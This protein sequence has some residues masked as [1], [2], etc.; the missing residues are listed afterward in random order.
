MDI[1][2]IEYVI[3]GKNTS[4]VK[5]PMQRKRGWEKIKKFAE[6]TGISDIQCLLKAAAMFVDDVI[7]LTEDFDSLEEI[8]EKISLILKAARMRLSPEKCTFFGINEA[9]REKLKR[10][11]EQGLAAAEETIAIKIWNGDIKE[12]KDQIFEYLGVWISITKGQISWNRQLE[13]LMNKGRAAVSFYR[14]MGFGRYPKGILSRLVIMEKMIQPKIVWGLIVAH[15]NGTQLNNLESVSTNLLTMLTGLP[16]N[17]TRCG[18]RILLGFPSMRYNL[19]QIRCVWHWIFMHPV[20]SEDN[21]IWYLSLD[22]MITEKHTEWAI[23]FTPN[24]N[25][26]RMGIRRENIKSL[27]QFISILKDMRYKGCLEEKYFRI[28]TWRGMMI[29][30]MIFA[31]MDEF[32]DQ[33]KIFAMKQSQWKNTT[34]KRLL[35]VLFERDIK[36]LKEGKSLIL[37]LDIAANMKGY[38]RSIAQYLEEKVTFNWETA[39]FTRNIFAVLTGSICA[40]WKSKDGNGMRKCLYCSEMAQIMIDHIVFECKTMGEATNWEMKN[41]DRNRIELN[42]LISFVAKMSEYLD[43]EKISI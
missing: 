21:V 35:K 5:I 7:I 19:Y 17:T 34:K 8:I 38:S 36:E 10:I 1:K 25:I 6:S 3:E 2:P 24:T 4:L 29:F 26:E 11:T 12:A 22:E 28:R 14:D 15:L 23:K 41:Q 33:K 32:I 37:R 30:T 20:R 13:E 16:I 27:P 9:K 31:E 18:I 43:K 39:K 40:N 42:I